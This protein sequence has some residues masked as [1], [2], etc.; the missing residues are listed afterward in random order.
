MFGDELPRGVEVFGGFQGQRGQALEAAAGE[1]GQGAGRRQ[2]QHA[3]YA[4]GSHGDGDA[5]A[6]GGKEGQRQPRGRED[7]HHDPHI[8]EGL[9]GD[10]GGNPRRQQRAEFIPAGDGDPVS[11]D[12][13]RHA[14]YDQH[15]SDDT[16]AADQEQRAKYQCQHAQ[17]TQDGT[18]KRTFINKIDANSS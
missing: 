8:Q 5:G 2:F 15:N 16:G 12:H 13:Q 18:Q 6:A 4:H 10:G 3:G 7:A 14:A 1:P 11:R 9:H 17:H